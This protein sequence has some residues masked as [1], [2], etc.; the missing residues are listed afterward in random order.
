MPWGP[1]APVAPVRPLGSL[2]S[3]GYRGPGAGG[4]CS[5]LVASPGQHAPLAGR[6]HR[7]MT[8]IGAHET[9]PAGAGIIHNVVPVVRRTCLPVPFIDQAGYRGDE[10]ETIIGPGLANRPKECN[11]DQKRYRE[12]K[13]PV[14]ISHGFLLP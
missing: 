14:G 2:G 5:A 4:S 12:S 7:I 3:G 9:E 10:K 13:K 6:R 11:G 1:V 8:Q